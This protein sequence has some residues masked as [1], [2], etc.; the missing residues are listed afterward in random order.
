VLHRRRSN[1]A[2]DHRF[3][4]AQRQ[5]QRAPI[6][7]DRFPSTDEIDGKL[8]RAPD[9]TF[10][11]GNPVRLRKREQMLESLQVTGPRLITVGR[12]MVPVPRRS[13]ALRR[14]IRPPR[15]EH[16]P[17]KD[18]VGELDNAVCERLFGRR[19]TM[20]TIDRRRKSLTITPR[21]RFGYIGE[22][23]E[24]RA[25]LREALVAI[26]RMPPR[27]RRRTLPRKIEI[28]ARGGDRIG[29]SKRSCDAIKTGIV[30]VHE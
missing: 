26:E 8:D 28:L 21:D 24:P 2:V 30:E 11:V 6:P 7:F 9:V 4:R 25:S 1:R 17:G 12:H 22:E 3:A 16:G 5:P 15:M 27:G 20:S 13:H 23:I 18:E 14:Y 19:V 10:I 29:I